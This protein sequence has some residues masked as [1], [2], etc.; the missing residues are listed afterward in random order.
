VNS[1]EA[2][3]PVILERDGVRFGLLQLT[4]VH[5]FHG[6]EATADYPGVATIKAHTAYRPQIERLRTLIRPGMPP[7]S[8]PGRTQPRSANYA[9]R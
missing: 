6:H 5:W 9:R 3:K 7:G 8:S 4:S 1:V 2:R